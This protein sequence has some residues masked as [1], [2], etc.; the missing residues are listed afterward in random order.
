MWRW[1]WGA[2]ASG[3]RV[4]ECRSFLMCDDDGGGLDWPSALL[5]PTGKGAA[6]EGTAWEVAWRL[7]PFGA[8]GSK[9]APNL[10]IG[11]ANPDHDPGHTCGETPWSYSLYPS[12]GDVCH[13]SKC[14]KFY[15]EV[16]PRPGDLVGVRLR[17]NGELQFRRNADA[18]RKA[19]DDVPAN[20]LPCV[21]LALPGLKLQLVDSPP[22]D[23]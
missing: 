8:C 21:T 2:M 17:D 11:A 14:W 20:T 3:L 9:V 6:D 5:E 7:E 22:R 12:D 16:A 10:Y 18:W 23:P 1:R 4:S 15:D 13:A 19:F